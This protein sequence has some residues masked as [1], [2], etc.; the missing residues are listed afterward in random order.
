M[1]PTVKNK[2]LIVVDNYIKKDFT[3]STNYI[4]FKMFQINCFGENF[5]FF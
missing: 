1:F 2:Y 5:T 3:S 4:T